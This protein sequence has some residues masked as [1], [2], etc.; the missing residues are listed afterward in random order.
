MVEPYRQFRLTQPRQ[1]GHCVV[2]ADPVDHLRVYAAH[3][4]GVMVLLERAHRLVWHSRS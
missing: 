3:G 4:G 1:Q 2:L